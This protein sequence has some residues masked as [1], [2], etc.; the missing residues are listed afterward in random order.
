MW[1]QGQLSIADEHIGIE[2]TKRLMGK[3]AAKIKSNKKVNK[4]A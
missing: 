3:Y 1:E 2:I 4:A